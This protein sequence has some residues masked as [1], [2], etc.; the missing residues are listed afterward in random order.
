MAKEQIKFD[1][2][3]YRRHNDKNKSM[4]HASLQECGAGRSVLVD[5]EGELIAGNG[6]FEQAQKLGLRTRIVETD[7]T[8]LVVVKRTDL[9]TDDAK[10]KKLAAMDNAT[11]DNVEWDTE[12]LRLD[13][14][15]SELQQMQIELPPVVSPD[16]FG[17]EF[18]LPTG[19]KQPYQQMTF[20]LHDEQ[21]AMIKAAL[22]EAKGLEEY[23]HAD[24]FGNTNS[25]GNALTLIIQQWADA[26]K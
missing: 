21:A 13:F 12:A 22:E 17:E 23:K 15:E 6:V 7:G 20:S 26:R 3:N 4:I 9:K 24:T 16:Q 10:R 25:N 11:A 19:D 18:S 5:N 8:E 1:R 2:R 14:S